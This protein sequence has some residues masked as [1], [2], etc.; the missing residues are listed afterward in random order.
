MH[1][2][3]HSHFCQDF[4]VPS[5]FRIEDL[6]YTA[7][8]IDIPPGNGNALSDIDQQHQIAEALREPGASEYM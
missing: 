2:H 3:T 5:P 7:L 8:N 1:T 6:P 4:S